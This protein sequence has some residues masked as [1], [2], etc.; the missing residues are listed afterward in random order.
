MR[1]HRLELSAFLAFAG[2]E[3]VDFDALGEAG[4]FL[5]QGRTGAGKTALLDAVCFAFYGEVPGARQD[6]ARLRSDHASPETPTQVVLEATLRGRRIRIARTPA[7]ERPKKVGDGTTTEPHRVRVVA[8]EEDGGETVLATRHEEARLELDDLLGMSRDQFCQVVLLPQGGFAR[9]LHARSDERE[10]LLGE[11]FDVGR[12]A[13]VERWLRDRR[14]EAERA[15]ATAMRV[16]RDVLAAAAQVA[17]AAPPEGADHAPGL[18]TSWLDEQLVVSEATAATAQVAA[19]GARE[20]RRSAEAAL[21]AG[22]E[23][24]ARREQHARA[25]RALADWDAK[26]AGR[27]AAASQLAAARRA[28]P[29]RALAEA[30]A[31]RT[32][33]AVASGRAAAEAMEAASA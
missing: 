11:L 23:L 30:L 6:A 16:V 15:L 26:R 20:A 28:A 12:F 14:H 3:T 32:G 1:L 31:D 2:T 24:A 17:D 18:A 4:L 29:V 33:E 21:A 10:H 5:L 22:V 27:D 13:D 19:G 25:A 9:F 8:I 7:H